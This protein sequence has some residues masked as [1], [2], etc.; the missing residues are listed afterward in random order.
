[1]C[2][3]KCEA[4]RGRLPCVNCP[5]FAVLD[6]LETRVRLIIESIVSC[7]LG[8]CRGVFTKVQVQRMTNSLSTLS[9][10]S[11]TVAE[12]HRCVDVFGD[13]RTFLRQCG[14]GF[15]Q[16]AE[17]GLPTPQSRSE[18]QIPSET[19]VRADGEEFLIGS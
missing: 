2:I 9:Q 8:V 14:Q 13:S 6:S 19:V 5:D 15:R 16:T 1:M 18:V 17:L 7:E 12:F 3:I 10:K 11:A 4:K